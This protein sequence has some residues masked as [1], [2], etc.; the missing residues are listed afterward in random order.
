MDTTTILREYDEI[1]KRVNK[2]FVEVNDKS[3]KNELEI[4]YFLD[5]IK[6]RP[7]IQYAN[8]YLQKLKYLKDEK[9]SRIRDIEKEILS[10]IDAIQS[11][12][13]ETNKY[14]QTDSQFRELIYDALKSRKNKDGF[15]MIKKNWKEIRRL[16]LRIPLYDEDTTREYV[17]FESLFRILKH[18]H[19]NDNKVFM[20]RNKKN[21]Q[22]W[23]S[24]Y[25]I[26]RIIEKDATVVSLFTAFLH[27]NQY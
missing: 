3:N 16:I 6:K 14:W 21:I 2:I 13:E 22:E 5:M 19:E 20:E 23:I 18:Y 8:E 15:Y 10:Y 27:Q 17:V 9:H 25:K 1:I 26:D 12:K 7:T 4:S 24:V 11:L